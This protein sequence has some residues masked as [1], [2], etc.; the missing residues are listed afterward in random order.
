MDSSDSDKEGLINESFRDVN[1][2][3]NVGPGY[4]SIQDPGTVDNSDLSYSYDCEQNG[5]GMLPQNCSKVLLGKF[6]KWRET[7]LVGKIRF[8]G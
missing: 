6:S 2:P 4:G 7:G 3:G 8:G 1:S 5:N